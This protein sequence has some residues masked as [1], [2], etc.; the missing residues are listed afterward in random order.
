MNLIK[1]AYAQITNPALTGIAGTDAAGGFAFY[2]GQ[3]WKTAIVVGGLAFLV[4]AI[5]GGLNWIT[6]GG[7]PKK[8]EAAQ[9]HFTNGVIGLIILV[10]SYAVVAFI[11]EILHINILDIDW[12][13]G[14]Q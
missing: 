5:M 1:P 8:V 6:A 14:G 13:F 12:T 9:K 2:V 7:D 4:Y 10:G 11:Q 3:L